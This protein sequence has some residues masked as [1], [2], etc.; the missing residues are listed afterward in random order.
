M[1]AE[2]HH[3]LGIVAHS[4]VQHLPFLKLL[5]QSHHLLNAL[6]RTGSVVRGDQKST[7]S[8]GSDK[9][10]LL[11]LRAGTAGAT[12]VAYI[13]IYIYISSYLAPKIANI[14]VSKRFHRVPIGKSVHRPTGILLDHLKFPAF[15]MSKQ[16]MDGT[17]FL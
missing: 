17:A 2:H 14:R 6:A 13:H 11:C 16:K 3:F 9:P 4:S 8:S 15:G 12:F 10:K 5:E 7:P 1:N